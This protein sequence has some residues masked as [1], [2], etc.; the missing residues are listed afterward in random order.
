MGDFGLTGGNIVNR[1][2]RLN[3]LRKLLKAAHNQR[4]GVKVAL[5]I[6]AQLASKIFKGKILRGPELLQIIKISIKGRALVTRHETVSL[7]SLPDHSTA[8]S[9]WSP[10]ACHF[11]AVYA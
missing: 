3:S 5:F 11:Q 2:S 6:M 9:R 10:I 8:F 7:S 4:V 1:Q